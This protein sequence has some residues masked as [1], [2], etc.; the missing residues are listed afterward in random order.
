MNNSGSALARL[1]LLCVFSFLCFLPANSATAGPTIVYDPKT[2][3]VLSQKDA[4][5]PWYPASLTKM[6]TA[7]VAFQAIKVGKV[8][9]SDPVVMSPRAASEPPSRLGLPVGTKLPLGL[10]VKA[11]L[12]RSANDLA[13]AIAEKV[14]GSVENFVRDMNAT[15]RSIGMT[16]SYFANTHGLPDPRQITTARDMAILGGKLVTEF[17]RYN[18]YYD[19][20][21]VKVRK[22]SYA[23]RNRAYLNGWN[24]AD[25]IKG[26]YICNSG[27]NLVAS[28]TVD[29]RRLIGVVLGARTGGSRAATAHS[30]L[31]K[32]FKPGKKVTG[33]RSDNDDYDGGIRRTSAKTGTPISNIKN[34][35]VSPTKLPKDMAPTICKHL[36]TWRR[37]RPYRLRRKWT[38]A[39]GK[40]KNPTAAYRILRTRLLNTFDVF[41]G[42]N[43][44]LIKL[45]PNRGY[46]PAIGNLD[47]TQATKLC[48]HIKAKS[49]PCTM[50]SPD[51]MTRLAEE[52]N[53]IE[54]AKRAKRVAAK[55][56][57]KRRSKKRRKKRRT[58]NK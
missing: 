48:K 31:K 3:H 6:M 42:G 36:G 27:F 14:S 32:A 30:I 17:S 4:G 37:V 54:K 38:V 15:A 52:D 39:F 55:K 49:K 1:A 50:L 22:R 34:G 53:A 35:L 51:Y 44:G 25:G 46:L 33:S 29:G 16:G 28:A 5:V 58:I 47:K 10:A 56:A 12:V 40:F 8:K 24:A 23:S 41:Y 21:A 57:K 13:V 19:S 7:Y 45:H 18:D 9:I 26:G 43:H 11:L 2:G 20:R